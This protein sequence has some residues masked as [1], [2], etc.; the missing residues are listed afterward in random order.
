MSEKS[1]EEG[2]A[3]DS[4]RE[5]SKGGEGQGEGDEGSGN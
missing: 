3:Q 4:T 1:E 2:G 5:D